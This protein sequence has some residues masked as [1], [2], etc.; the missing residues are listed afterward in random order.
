MAEAVEFALVVPIL[1][2]VTG[3]VAEWGWYLDREATLIQAARDA[4]F[5][6]VLA[7]DG[8]DVRAIARTRMLAAL[9]AEGLARSSSDAVV[10]VRLVPGA[11]G[12]ALAMDVVVPYEPLVRGMHTPGRLT[13]AHTALLVAR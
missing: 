2:L 7:P 1:V 12:P 4:V 10:D 6:A 8:A 11:F 3:A 9:S 5:F 13:A